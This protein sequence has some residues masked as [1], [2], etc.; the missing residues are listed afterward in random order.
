MRDIKGYEGLYAV[1]SCGK[2][3]SYRRNKFLKP[4][5]QLTG[6]LMVQLKKDDKTKNCYVHRLVAEAYLD[7]PDR[8][9]EVNH[10]NEDKTKNHVSN[11][12][13]CTRSYNLNYG[14]RIS[15]YY[16]AVYCVELDKTFNSLKEAAQAFNL[17][18]TNLSACLN[19]RL[20][21][22]AGYHWKYV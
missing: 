11:L 10:K 12:E 14:T 6:Y 3:Y 16:K 20:K 7:N 1:T 9:P 2:V 22:F 19:G 13:W 18:Y 21:T 15:Q 8:L 5:K 4:Q 17:A